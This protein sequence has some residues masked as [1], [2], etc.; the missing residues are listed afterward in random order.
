MV[1]F[2]LSS[3]TV[4]SDMPLPIIVEHLDDYQGQ[5]SIRIKTIMA[6]WIFHKQGA[7]LAA[8][9]DSDGAD[10]IS[11]RPEG[12]AS[13][14][15]RGFPNLI[16]P[17]SDFHPGGENADLEIIEQGP[18]YIRLQAR[19]RDGAW[20]AFWDVDHDLAR[21]TLTK[22]P[23]PYWVLY[24]G[25][26]GGALDLDHDYYLLPDSG[27]TPVTESFARDLPASN[28][29]DAEWIAFGDDRVDRLLVIVQ[30]H[31]DDKLDQFYEMN[32]AMT[33]FGFGREHRCCGKHLEQVPATYTIGF[34]SHTDPVWASL[35]ARSAL[36][37]PIP[38]PDYERPR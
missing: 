33:V 15:Y 37:H 9:L 8:L 34:T 31:D 29:A 32:G 3:C 21:F 24:E 14:H 13:G 27:P 38:L 36:E 23:R 1:A 22:A 20:E 10:W 19:T 26:P 30:H 28:P 7:S 12:G 25:T 5:P 2:M 16:H 17:E 35:F 18:H 6:T 4:S 11:Y